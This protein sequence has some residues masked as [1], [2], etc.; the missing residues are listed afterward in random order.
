[1]GE[2][3]FSPAVR[4]WFEA[5]F[6]TPT[7]A[8]TKGWPPIARGEHTLVLAP[9]GS[10]KTLAAFL[11]AIDR[12]ASSARPE[13]LG[14][15]VV[16][17]SPLRA[18]A[19]D[20]ER[21]LR[22]PLVGI[23]RA[24][25]RLGAPL[26]H[27]PRVGVRTGDTDAAERRRLR[28]DPPDVLITTPESLYLL[29]TSAARE[30]LRDVETVI[31][32]E[33]HALVPTKRGAHL[34][35]SLERLEEL[36]GREVQ[37]I[38]LSATQRPLDEVARFLG[39]S[40]RPG[41]PREVT[42]VDAGAP[43]ALQ[44][45][46]VVP[47]EDMAGLGRPLEV[48]TDVASA[49]AGPAP[50]AS[51]WPAVHPV[52][53]EA[54]RA[55]RSTIVFVND[56]RSAERLAARLNELAG[57][58]LVR[59][60]HGSLAREQRLAV[61]DA[62]KAGALRGLVAT[63]SLELGI[64]MGAV[65][66]VIQ[67]GAPPSVTS[68]LQ[69]VGRAGHHVG[70]PSVAT[71]IPRW[72]GDLLETAVIA[73]RMLR[74][75]IEATRY[76]RNPLDV[77]AQQLVA[78]CTIEERAVDDLLGL[79][80]R[81]A[82]YE[83]LAEDLFL[84]TL[85]LLA[86]A[87]PSDRFAELRPRLV[88][89]RAAATV[90]GRDGARM[91][92][93]TSGGTIPDRGLYGVFT[94]E[95][96]RVGE[97]D[98]EMVFE[99][100]A[101]EVIVLGASSWRIE[102][103]TRDRVLVSPAPGEPGKLPFWKAPG[104]GRPVEL[105]R[106]IGR[107]TRELRGRRR[108]EALERLRAEVG[109][110]AWAA[111]NLVAY[112][113]EQAAA[114]GAVPDD[115]TIVVERFRDELGDRR[116]CVLSP[117]GARVHAPWALAIE[118]RL[119]ERYGP[120]PGVGALWADDGIVL[121]LP[122]AAD[123][124]DPADLLLDPDG[125]EERIAGLVPATAAFAGAFRE[126]AARALLLP[127][128]RPGRRTPLWVQRQRAGD[129]LAEAARHPGFP[130]LLEAA[131]EVLRDRFDVAALAELMRDLR[132]RRV[133]V[134]VVD[135]DG[136]SPFARSLLFRWI[137]VAMYEG[138]APLAERRA[139]ALALDRELLRELLGE[140]DL[141]E[142]LDPATIE[143]IEL[144][145]QRLAPERRARSLDEV[146]DL[147]RAL[148]PLAA[149]E[150]AA[151][152]DPPSAAGELG[153]RLEA[154]GRA[155]RVRVAGVERLAA[156]EDAALLRDALG[157]ALPPGLPSS[158]TAPADAPLEALVAREARARGPFTPGEVAA[159]LGVG[160]PAVRA[161]LERLTAAGVVVAGGFRAG[162]LEREWCDAGV[163]RR[164]RRSSLARLRA[165]VE[166][167]E[168]DVFARF[169]AAWQGADRPRAGVGALEEAVAR[170][171]GA[172]IPAS[173]L[174]ADV[175]P[176]RVL[177]YRPTELD[178][179]VAAGDLVWV[180]AG[181]IGPADGRVRLVLRELAPALLD[182]DE[183]Q[184][185]EGPVHDAIRERLRRRGASFWPDLVAA[186]GA[187]DERVL[188]ACLWD[189]VWAGEVTNDTLAPLRAVVGARARRAARRPRPGALRRAG[190]PAGAGRWSLV[191]DLLDPPVPQAER[192]LALTRRL[193][194]RQGVVTR[195]G[196]LAEGVPGGFAAVYPVLRALEERGEVRR[197][198][199]VAGLGAAQF[200]LPGAVDRLRSHR[201]RSEAPRVCALAAA[202]PA[203]PYGAI[204][205]W[206][207]TP[208]RPS[209]SAGAFVV[210]VDGAPAVFVERGGGTLATFAGAEPTLWADAVAALVKDGRLRRLEVRRV[211]GVPVHEHPA[212]AAL[213]AAGFV[214]GYRGLVLR[215]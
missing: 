123:D 103:I 78:I 37:R 158:L 213:G 53:L 19:A 24:A 94:L 164:I 170:L 9:T 73:D 67:I 104:P 102:E 211:D 201:S 21:N 26:A 100:R 65:D 105:G 57:E 199:F 13:R 93:V 195:E 209:R 202:D 186:A 5:S 130:I 145:L 129:L 188:L 12:L 74:G 135:T 84:A 68:G 166:P 42:V 4:S 14:T 33:I 151:R 177:G 3:P 187:A 40:R 139:A 41:E 28:R 162:G 194:D 204:L 98:E 79:V 11:W 122:D 140:E 197:G 206:P 137:A 172:P 113:D 165:E 142:L 99:S 49:A 156:V 107:F 43:P 7:P 171:Q 27:R 61:E 44:L 159:R 153:R 155:I 124:L 152:V 70:E 132:A 183:T 17:V 200:A 148:G 196:V 80:R 212:A 190:P 50:R 22:A 35:L 116:A 133:R 198:A 174:E 32:D 29:L 51:I 141:R 115:R 203:Q 112:L 101:G 144:E 207:S 95:G 86:G 193:L 60:H 64:D 82:C 15:R 131:R 182:A 178:A 127:R 63:S 20:V 62:L 191:E 25:E 72:R 75:E 136:A 10:G 126:A 147:L 66:L 210:L 2:L 77:L 56:R 121:R 181:P 90:R 128:R 1:M 163:L 184:R 85:E 46:V 114:T 214:Q 106:A 89:D 8:Q 117:L 215:G 109:L 55:H 52:V 81:A 189:L 108:D 58:E 59:A 154:E 36:A 134:A 91:L 47:V 146:H 180:G 87:Y 138:D 16:Y 83:D 39:G 111:E 125:L 69:R 118:E 97:L 149:D 45:S 76:L 30:T 88:W 71:M 143:A 150:L 173:I 48:P 157:V 167:V 205:S 23:E 160:A 31:V 176:A 208:G 54:I 110:D 92:A 179:L 175:L 18:L 96:G 6:G 34:A 161:S 168:P 169:L 119:R 192:R 185:P 120:S 38:G